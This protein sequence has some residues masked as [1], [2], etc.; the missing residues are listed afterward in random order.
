MKAIILAAGRGSRL[1]ELTKDRPKCLVMLRGRPLLEW[2]IKALRESGIQD[3]LVV[4][5]YCKDQ[6]TGNFETTENPRWDQTNMVSTLM[7]ARDW[8]KSSPCIV[9]YA[10]IVYPCQAVKRLIQED[11]PLTILYDSNWLEL[12]QQRFDDPF[13]DAESFRLDEQGYLVDIG[14]KNVSA[15]E[16]QGQYMGLLKFTP[17]SAGCVFNL[18]DYNPELCDRL[19]MTALLRLLIEKG[20][21]IRAVPWDGQWCEVDSQDDLQVAKEI[22]KTW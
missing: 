3:I 21:A 16:I 14:R 2:Q 7:A 1:Y 13:S 10:D 22:T 8:L 4:R 19:D 12:W 15:R 17:E 5:G 18:L 9:S 11:S 6:I 20:K